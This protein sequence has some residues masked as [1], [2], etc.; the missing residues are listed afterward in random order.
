MN[1]FLV[2]LCPLLM[3]GC[4]NSGVKSTM[5]GKRSKASGPG[6]D[7]SKVKQEAMKGGAY[8]HYQSGSIRVLDKTDSSVAWGL[9]FRLNNK[10]AG[11]RRFN[12][13]L[14][15][16]EN[17]HWDHRELDLTPTS[18]L[19]VHAQRLSFGSYADLMIAHFKFS[20]TAEQPVTSSSLFVLIDLS[21]IGGRLL[22]EGF[23][24]PQ[25]TTSDLKGWVE[26][27]LKPA[28]STP[29]DIESEL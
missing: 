27:V 23:V 20:N 8:L 15:A 29:S 5:E 18:R 7:L 6:Q 9:Q 14:K 10:D 21:P 28:K 25:S 22:K 16:G 17:K 11:F 26:A 13:D 19:A 1:K 12:F 2:L 3:L 24:Y 4:G